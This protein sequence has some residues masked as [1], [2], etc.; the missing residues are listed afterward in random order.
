MRRRRR[1]KTPSSSN[2]NNNNDNDNNTN[3][4]NNNNNGNTD[5]A[6]RNSENRTG[7][8]QPTSSRKRISCCNCL[9]LFIIIILFMAMNQ[10]HNF[11]NKINPYSHPSLQ[12]IS[13]K[14]QYLNSLQEMN[15]A[16]KSNKNFV[17]IL[18]DD[19]GFDFSYFGSRAVP[20]FF[21]LC[22]LSLPRGPRNS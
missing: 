13:L 3:D 1:T 14:K 4:N 22:F 9:I 17:V 6:T 8:I 2:N 16:K 5:N 20:Q 12:H 19:A 21:A 18:L 11:R 15:L 7:N 10:L